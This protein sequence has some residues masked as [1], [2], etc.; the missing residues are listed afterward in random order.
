VPTDEPADDG[1]GL[2]ALPGGL[3]GTASQPP[4]AIR[5]EV[6]HTLR[7]ARKRKRATLEQASDQTRLPRRA[8][9]ALEG[10]GDPS[11]LPEP[12]YDRYFLREYARYLEVPEE[13]LLT[14]LDP[15]QPQELEIP[16]EL[17]P[18]ERRPRRWPVLVLATLSGSAF[19][20]L[21]VM[22]M[23]DGSPADVAAGTLGGPT[24]APRSQLSAQPPPASEAPPVARGVSAVLRLSDR[25]WIEATVDGRVVMAETAQAGATLRFRANRTLVLRLGNAGG[26]R[27]TVN[28]ESVAT[29]GTGD[30][31]DL[32]F[33]WSHGRLTQA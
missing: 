27:L 20:A 10:G 26:A 12:P 25:C 21:A 22:R 2:R 5:T 28:G 30:I 15:R 14:A 4:A 7:K 11:D 9:A 23:T 1:V 13:P 29:G 6:A 31:V 8:L 32:S 19:I 33:T 24:Q 3:H 17:L 18:V 16:V